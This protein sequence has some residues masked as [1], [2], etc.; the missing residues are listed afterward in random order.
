MKF[1]SKKIDT[2]EW[3]G[4]RLIWTIWD[5]HSPKSTN[6]L[7]LKYEG[8]DLLVTSMKVAN[9]EYLMFTELP[10]SMFKDNLQFHHFLQ[11]GNYFKFERYQEPE[12]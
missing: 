8:D 5:E 10:L 2:A 12:Q 9:C 3:E 4:N 1:E 6:I 7:N 11:P